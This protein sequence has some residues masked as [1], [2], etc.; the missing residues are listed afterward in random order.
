[1]Q[2]QL[3]ICSISFRDAYQIQ[4]CNIRYRYAA[5]EAEMLTCSRDAAPAADMQNICYTYAAPYAD[6]KHQLQ[7]CGNRYRNAAPDTAIQH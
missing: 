3:Q 4:I 5:Q 2:H 7:I 1:M 6:M